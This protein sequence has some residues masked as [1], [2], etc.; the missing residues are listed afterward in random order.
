VSNARARGLL[1]AIDLPTGSVRDDVVTS[2]RS[3]EQVLAL[4]CGERTL[5]VRPAL[6]ITE[7]EIDYGCDAIGRVLRK[8]AS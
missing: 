1:G 6:S 4:A 7:A 5:R 8:L 2:L 3:T